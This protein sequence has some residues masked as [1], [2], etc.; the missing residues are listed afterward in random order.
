MVLER[1]LELEQLLLSFQVLELGPL[2]L[3]RV[4]GQ[5]PLRLV[6]LVLVIIQV[7]LELALQLELVLEVALQLFQQVLLP[8]LGLGL[9]QQVVRQGVDFHLRLGVGRLLVSQQEL[10]LQR[11]T[12]SR[13]Q[14]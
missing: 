14:R 9:P 8:R 6:A 2:E 3:V 12:F 7:Q 13:W 4:Q 1:E 10:I 5:L 11:L